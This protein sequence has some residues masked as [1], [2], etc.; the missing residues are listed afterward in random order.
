M[1]KLVLAMAFG[2]FALSSAL[3][4]TTF[5]DVDADG[6]GGVTYAEAVNAGLPWSEEQF[7][8]ADSDANGSLDEQEFRNATL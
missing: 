5:Q 7:Q 1:K 2:T 8:A 3:A 6:D 4:E